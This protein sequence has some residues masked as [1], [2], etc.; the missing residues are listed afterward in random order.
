MNQV[1]VGLIPGLEEGGEGEVGEGRQLP[2]L[3]RPRR[4]RTAV[5]PPRVAARREG[6][7]R[8]VGQLRGRH[9]RVLV[10]LIL[11]HR[12]LL[13]DD[14]VLVVDRTFVTRGVAE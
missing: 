1:R 11:D 2:G 14:R 10:L 8:R 9:G 13:S 5:R 3:A 4:R 6:R 12:F 7:R